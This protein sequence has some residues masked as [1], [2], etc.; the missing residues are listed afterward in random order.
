[1]PRS[2]C[3]VSAATAG[4]AP[5]VAGSRI[6]WFGAAPAEALIAAALVCTGEADFRRRVRARLDK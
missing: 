2:S 4:P 3:V 6:V 5:G 1:M